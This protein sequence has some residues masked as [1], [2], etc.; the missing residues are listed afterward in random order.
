MKCLITTHL[1]DMLYTLPPEQQK[2]LNT[3]AMA[4]IDKFRKEGKCKE[5]YNVPGLNMS[6]SIWEIESAEELDQLFLEFPMFSFMDFDIYTLSDFDANIKG[7][8]E[9]LERMIVK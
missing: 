4:F 9:L 1:K 8:N 5:I 2:E 6:V 7:T 3:G